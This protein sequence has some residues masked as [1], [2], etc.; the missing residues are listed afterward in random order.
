LKSSESSTKETLQRTAEKLE[1]E[2]VQFN[3]KVADLETLLES[4]KESYQE[5]LRKVAQQVEVSTSEWK[6]K[7]NNQEKEYSTEK[8]R[9]L[10][11]KSCVKK[12]KFFFQD[13][14]RI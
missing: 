8:S 4:S 7:L 2:R 13:F 9:Y 10:F 1:A 14:E 6:S 12:I 11:I 5:E 3:S